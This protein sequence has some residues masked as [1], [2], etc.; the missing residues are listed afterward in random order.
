MFPNSTAVKKTA[1]AAL[2]GCWPKACAVAVMAMAFPLVVMN[3]V[4]VLEL[5]FKTKAA[6][7]I[8]RIL[9]LVFCTIF[10]SPLFLGALR[11]F[12]SIAA[13]GNLCV[14]DI[15]YY[16]SSKKSFFRAFNF[17][18]FLFGKIAIE[19]MLLLI[20]SFLVDFI[21]KN[22]RGLFWGGATPLWLENIWIFALV[23]RIIAVAIIL[24]IAMRYYLSFFIFIS[25]DSIDSLDAIQKSLMPAKHSLGYFTGLF[26]SLLGWLA[27]SVFVIPMVFTLPYLIMCYIVHSRYSVVFYNDILISKN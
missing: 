17:I 25:N 15:F 21:S 26:C 19:G 4:S 16:Y 5:V 18:V 3:L 9:A 14:A 6:V 27:L 24:Y 12:W 2:R 7:L 8:I 10:G 20:P 23:L 22:S 13:G 1:L 11:V